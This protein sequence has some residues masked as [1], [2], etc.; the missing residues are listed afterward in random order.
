MGLYPPEMNAINDDDAADD[1]E[2]SPAEELVLPWTYCPAQDLA[3][4]LN[5]VEELMHL[6]IILITVR[7]LFSLCPYLFSQ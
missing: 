5:L 7:V 3:I 2:E 6:I 1:D 4:C